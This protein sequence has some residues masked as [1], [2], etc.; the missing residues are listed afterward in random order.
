MKIG[1]GAAAPGPI[2]FHADLRR[3]YGAA[4]KSSLRFSAKRRDRSNSQSFGRES[5]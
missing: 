3:P 5:D 1:P 2:S 4:P